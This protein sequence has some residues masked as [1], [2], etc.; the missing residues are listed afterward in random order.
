MI[1]RFHDEM[2]LPDNYRDCI[3]RLFPTMQKLQ[4]QGKIRFTGITEYM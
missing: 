2:T 4:E 3:D 1:L